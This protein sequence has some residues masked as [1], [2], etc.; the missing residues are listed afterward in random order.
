MR[1][2]M[3][4]EDGYIRYDWD[5]VSQDLTATLC[6]IWIFVIQMPARLRLDSGSTLINFH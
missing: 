4:A 6:I 3:I 1:E 2:L 5:E